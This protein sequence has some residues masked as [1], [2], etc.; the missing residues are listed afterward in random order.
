MQ[1]VF[2]ESALRLNIKSQH[3]RPH[4]KKQF[5]FRFYCLY[6]FVPILKKEMDYG[7]AIPNSNR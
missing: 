7:F 6:I 3:P 2:L 5:A 4:Q 1:L